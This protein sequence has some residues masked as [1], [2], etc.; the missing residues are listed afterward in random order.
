MLCT[1]PTIFSDGLAKP[2]KSQTL[3][4]FTCF[5]KVN[6]YLLQLVISFTAAVVVI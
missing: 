4:K 2:S 1:Q 3:L 6:M 5:G